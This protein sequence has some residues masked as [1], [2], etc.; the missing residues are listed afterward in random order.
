VPFIGEHPE[1]GGL[2]LNAGHFRN[3]VVMG[4]AAARL[5]ADLLLKR[6]PI[7]NP[8]PYALIRG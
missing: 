5:T 3:G 7:L 6:D 8:A 2:F 1:I 4:L